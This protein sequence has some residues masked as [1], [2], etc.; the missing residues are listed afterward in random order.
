ML[1]EVGG[2]VYLAIR[3]ANLDLVEGLRDDPVRAAVMVQVLVHVAS[4]RHHEQPLSMVGIGRADAIEP[5]NVDALVREWRIRRLAGIA[6]LLPEDVRV[7]YPELTGEIG[8]PA[9]ETDVVIRDHETAG[10]H[11]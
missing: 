3:V 7:R 4:G 9:E 5:G 11:K 6:H 8:V 10:G 1:A 2:G